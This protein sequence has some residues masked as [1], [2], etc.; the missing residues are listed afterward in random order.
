MKTMYI[1]GIVA[2][3]LVGGI[4]AF[5]LFA[6][7]NNVQVDEKVNEVTSDMT[8]E[9]AGRTRVTDGAFS[10]D[11]TETE[12][13]WTGS[14]TLVANYKD[15]GTLGIKEG[16]VSVEE[17]KITKAEFA[18]DMA[19]ILAESTGGGAGQE[20][21]TN[22]LKSAD[23]FD[24]EK[25][26]TATFTATKVTPAE[27]VATS[28]MYTVSGDLTI[29]GT[30]KEV[31]FPMAMYMKD[32]SFHAKATTTVDRTEFNVRYGSDKFFDNLGDKVIDDNFSVTF[33]L[34]ANTK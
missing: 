26:P 23:F 29:K 17:G 11:T 22:H 16:S 10:V 4:V 14:K 19:T 21:L 28:F 2:L 32:G 8:D 34:I 33:H 31:T 24:V 15:T 20:M 1:A 25:Y 27:D 12:V 5:K 13:R 7:Q 3:V 6:K 9:N 18:F 30:T